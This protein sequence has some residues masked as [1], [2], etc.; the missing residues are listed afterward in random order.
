MSA[1]DA[2][3]QVLA[4]E[5]ASVYGYGVIAAQT[6]GPAKRA[7]LNAFDVH[8][9]RRDQLRGLVVAAGATPVEAALAYTLPFEVST[10]AAATRLAA[11][12]EREAALSLGALVEAGDLGHREFAARALQ[13]AA[14]RETYW[15]GTPPTL[16]GLP[17]P[18]KPSPTATPTA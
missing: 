14:V 4:T 6:S 15:R 5:H 13:D 2:L 1:L 11:D 8:R 10:P 12:T 9:A 17:T 3:Q 18:A 7:A 16:P